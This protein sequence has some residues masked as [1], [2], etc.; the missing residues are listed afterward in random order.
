MN[1]ELNAR[2]KY[3]DSLQDLNMQYAQGEVKTYY[4]IEEVRYGGEVFEQEVCGSFDEAVERLRS[5]AK[6]GGPFLNVD[7]YQHK[8]RIATYHMLDGAVL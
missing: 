4:V 8:F 5:W 2:R 3:L 7:C 1:E 6:N